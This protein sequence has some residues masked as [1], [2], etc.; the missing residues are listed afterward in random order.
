MLFRSTSTSFPTAITTPCGV[1]MPQS[2]PPIPTN[3]ATL[4]WEWIAQGAL[5]N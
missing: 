5:N 3:E 2:S 4:I 1:Q